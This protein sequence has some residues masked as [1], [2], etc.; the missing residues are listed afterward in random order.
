MPWQLN[1]AKLVLL[2]EW[3]RNRG[4]KKKIFGQRSKSCD[5]ALLRQWVVR[6]WTSL[7]GLVLEVNS[8][9]TFKGVEN[10]RTEK[11]ARLEPAQILLLRTSKALSVTGMVK[12]D[13][14]SSFLKAFE[15]FWH[16]WFRPFNCLIS[17]FIYEGF[18]DGN[19]A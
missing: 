14:M 19:T 6:V 9:M 7:P 11:S 16:C 8:N 15:L 12:T 2:M 17:I 4:P 18:Q 10:Y 5:E 3:L 1:G 13:Y